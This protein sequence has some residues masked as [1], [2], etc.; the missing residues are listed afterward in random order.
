[1]LLCYQSY[2]VCVDK[3]SSAA[4]QLALLYSVCIYMISFKFQPFGSSMNILI[5]LVTSLFR[6]FPTK[7]GPSCRNRN[8]T[9]IGLLATLSPTL[10]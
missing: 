4:R 2:V 9:G 5:N 1:M 7:N 8:L 10:C 3:F 6:L